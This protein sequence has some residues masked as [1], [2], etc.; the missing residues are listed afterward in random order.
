MK[1]SEAVT[2]KPKKGDLVVAP[3]DDP[4]PITTISKGVAYIDAGHSRLPVM[5]KQLKFKSK[6]GSKT[7]WIAEY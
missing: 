2:S 7:T 1:L 5:L 4:M 6:V 3:G